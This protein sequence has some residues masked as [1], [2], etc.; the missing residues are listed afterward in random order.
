MSEKWYVDENEL[1]IWVVM[2]NGD[3]T[4]RELKNTPG[5]RRNAHLIAA[6]PEMLAELKKS[7]IDLSYA[8]ENGGSL[9]AI[10][11]WLADLDRVIALAEGEEQ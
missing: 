3:R 7:R 1:Y 2:A 4:F 9:R 10:V 6:A 8:K 5:S 11:Q